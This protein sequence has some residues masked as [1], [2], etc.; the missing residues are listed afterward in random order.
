M[1]TRPRTILLN[2]KKVVLQEKFD[3]NIPVSQKPDHSQV[4]MP[5]FLSIGKI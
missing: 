2:N 3:K 1:K 5:N 4:L